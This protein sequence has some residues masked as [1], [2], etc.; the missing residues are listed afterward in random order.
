MVRGTSLESDD[1]MAGEALA[2]SGEKALSGSRGAGAPRENGERI[3]KQE[4]R[5]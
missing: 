1:A 2:Q 3:E 4:S 5:Y